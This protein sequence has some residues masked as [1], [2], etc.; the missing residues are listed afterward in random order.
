MPGG[1]LGSLVLAG[2]VDEQYLTFAT[3]AVPSI[4]AIDSQ[5]YLR[6]PA[7]QQFANIAPGV[8]DQVFF[9]RLETVQLYNYTPLVCQIINS[10][11][12]CS[13][14]SQ[15]TFNLDANGNLYLS[16]PGALPAGNAIV[17]LTVTQ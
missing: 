1:N 9:D 14:G 15:N 7:T 5:G 6:D 12:F 11:L 3:G 8:S 10:Q 16:A 13:S 4:L 2:N 17:T